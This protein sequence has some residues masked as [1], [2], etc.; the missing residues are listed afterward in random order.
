[1]I[2]SY[3]LQVKS[4]DNIFD[5]MLQ[6]KVIFSDLLQLKDDEEFS[7]WQHFQDT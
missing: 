3:M 5:A 7:L 2:V 1:M 6:F 4:K